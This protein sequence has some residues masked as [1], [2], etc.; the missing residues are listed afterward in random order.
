MSKQHQSILILYYK[1]NCPFSQKVLQFLKETNQAIPLKNIAEDLSAKEELTHLGGK[2][3]TP[4][5]FIDGS[6]L[7]ESQAIIDY[8]QTHL[9]D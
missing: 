6:P 7:Y 1:P 2:A 4:C 3:Q 5:L 9:I 8:L